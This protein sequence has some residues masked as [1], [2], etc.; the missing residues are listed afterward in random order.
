VLLLPSP[1][2]IPSMLSF[3]LS[4]SLVSRISLHSSLGALLSS[5]DGLSRKWSEG[6]GKREN[7]GTK[8]GTEKSLGRGRGYVFGSSPKRLEQPHFELVHWSLLVVTLNLQWLWEILK[9]MC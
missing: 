2:H 9:T 5:K 8:K 1:L 6:G 4:L 3:S 7:F